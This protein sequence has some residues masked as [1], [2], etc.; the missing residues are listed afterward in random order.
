[1]ACPTNKLNTALF[2]ALTVFASTNAMAVD[3]PIT[4]ESGV[5]I[6][7]LDF[8]H[9]DLPV[10]D[11]SIGLLNVDVMQL[12]GVT[13]INS[14]FVNM[15]RGGDWVV[16]NLPVLP[17]SQYPYPNLSVKFDLDVDAGT[18]LESLNA[19]LIYSDQVHEQA[20][21][22]SETTFDV[23]S[24]TVSQGGLST[25]LPTNGS[26][27]SPK[28]TPSL[29]PISFGDVTN[30][31]Q[32]FQLD[33][34]NI[35]T[36]L[37]QCAPMSVA[38][39]LQF[40][41]NTTNLELPHSH[42]AGLEGDSSLVGQ[43][44]TAMNRQSTSRTSGSGVRW[45]NVIKGKLQYLADN[46]LHERIET[47]HWGFY[48]DTDYASSNGDKTAT[49]QGQ[50]ALH[51]NNV[52][53]AMEGGADCEA[54]Y[55]WPE[56]ENNWGA[57]AIDLVAAGYIAGQPFI[58]ESS[59]LDQSSDT[60][61]AGKS[62]FLFSFLT[63]GEDGG[64][65]MNGS[66]QELGIVMCQTFT[67]APIPTGSSL[68]PVG[69]DYYIP[70]MELTIDNIIDPAGHICCV[71]YPPSS[72]NLTIEDGVLTLDS[73][74]T[75]VS[76]LPITLDLNAEGG[77]SG[78]NTSE[79][80]GFSDIGSS[81][82]GTIG[83]ESIDATITLG[84]NG[85]L[86]QEQPIT[87]EVTMGPSDY[88]PWAYEEAEPVLDPAIRVNGFRNS[89]SLVPGDPLSIGLSLTPGVETETAEWWVVAQFGELIFSFN[90]DSYSW[91]PGLAPTVALPAMDIP[92][93]SLYSFPDGLPEGDFNFIFG[94][95]NTPNNTVD[96]D[97]LQYDM[98]NVNIVA[99]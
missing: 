88:W 50:G 85:G 10:L 22:G 42:V 55:T 89:I 4:V 84:T 26:N 92:S 54:G 14:G 49:S 40:L 64:L 81:I 71:M 59:D 93:L 20:P 77:I 24:E 9:D 57:H 67:P 74:S 86:P 17:D 46:D 94:L 72:L 90:L 62:G 16:R 96:F 37:N 87:F 48:G 5:T 18:D 43:L 52:I 79:I 39:S 73:A 60:K 76:W 19:Y 82:N 25:E 32:I 69:T 23:G 41:A 34:P 35:E 70:G 91:V 8:P 65:S 3:V 53:E 80:A 7:Q 1:M 11:S 51:F 36:A 75:V 66:G 27:A 68:P 95:D 30:N 63:D 2:L 38:N 13:S 61:G 28:V 47:K 33:H 83:L 99:P 31:R 78:T 98:V 15:V 12:R 21:S 6:S 29:D 97:S 56:G 44:G 58:I 45:D